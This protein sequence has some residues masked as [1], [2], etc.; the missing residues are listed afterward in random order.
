VGHGFGPAVRWGIEG[1]S[2]LGRHTTFY[3]LTQGY[4]VRDVC[5]TRTNEHA[6]RRRQGKTDALD[7][8][9][10][11]RE[12]LAD[13][14]LPLA[15]KRA[16][17]GA[18]PDPTLEQ[19]GL[20]HQERRSL[21]ASRQHLLNE[22]ETLLLALPEEIREA[23]PRTKEVRPRLQALA[24]LQGEWDGPT[25]LRL[26]CCANATTRSWSWTGASRSP[27][28]SSPRWWMRLAP[29]CASYPASLSAPPRN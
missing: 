27:S 9:R 25:R 28:R 4:D 18:A 29:P 2:G 10:I 11:G 5:P 21:L 1:A 12:V 20:W 3:L 17:P 13:P 24:T 16:E 15:L 6:R 14:R 23:L 19:L 7:A 8:E 22:A 26:R